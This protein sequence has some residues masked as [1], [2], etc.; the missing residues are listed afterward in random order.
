M[1]CHRDSAGK[2]LNIGGND[3]HGIE[4]DYAFLRP[5]GA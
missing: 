1:H 4:R 3:H 2:P 5:P